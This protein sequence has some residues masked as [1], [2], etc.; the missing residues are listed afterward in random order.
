[1]VVAGGTA[2]T[3][4]LVEFWDNAPPTVPANLASSGAY[5]IRINSQPLLQLLLIGI[6]LCMIFYLKELLLLL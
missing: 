5:T 3:N 6:Y 4:P 1:M 2:L